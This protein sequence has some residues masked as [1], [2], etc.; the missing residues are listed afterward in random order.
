MKR[1]GVVFLTVIL[2]A[3]LAV[4]VLSATEATVMRFQAAISGDGSAQVTVTVNLRL[5]TAQKDLTFP[6]PANARNVTLNGAKADT[7]RR[8]EAKRIDLSDTLGKMAGEFTF[9]VNYILDD[10]VA[11][12]EAGLPM[13][14]LPILSGFT[15]PVADLEFTVSLPDAVEAKPAFSSGYHHSSIEEDLQAAVSGNLITGQSLKALKDQETLVMTLDVPETMFPDTPIVFDRSLTEAL[16]IGGTLLIALLYWLIF[17]RNGP[18]RP[19]ETPTAPDGFGA[20]EL[21]SLLCLEGADLTLTVFTW[22]QLG[23]VLIQPDRNGRVLLH[24]RMEMGN[25]R[26]E[27]EQKLFRQLF[28]KRTVVDATSGR[29]AELSLRAKTLSSGARSMLERSSGNPRIFRLLGACT[30]VVCGFYVG[31]ALADGGV[32]RWLWGI[33]LGLLGG[34]SSMSVQRLASA[35]FLLRK[36]PVYR[37]LAWCVL[38]LGLGFLANKGITALILAVSQ[39]AVGFMAAY[40]GKRTQEG[41]RVACSVLGLRKYLKGLSYQDLRRISQS[42]PELFHN[43]APYA[44]A[45]GV[46]KRFAGRFGQEGI[47]GCP[48]LTTGMDGHRSAGEWAVLM[49]RTVSDMD[50]KQRQKTADRLRRILCELKK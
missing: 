28:G 49:R 26:S 31:F 10:V 5:E 7:W 9:T 4:P 21:G 35:L 41:R 36:Q 50:R 8:G 46:D 23:Y 27:F 17:L 48:Y 33:A 20:G 16:A 34:Y 30:G 29:Y 38:W 6:V 25:E 37:A 3:V 11:E 44:L 40:G 24:K 32:L 15:Y 1:I 12:N 14:E 42:D 47:S 18:L 22:G 39:L 45:L 43:L 2:L 19:R 13:V